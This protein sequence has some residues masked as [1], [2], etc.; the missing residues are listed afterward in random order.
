VQ[1]TT[2]ETREAELMKLPKKTEERCDA[3]STEWNVFVLRSFTLF[4]RAA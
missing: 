1:V 4:S 2:A 3:A